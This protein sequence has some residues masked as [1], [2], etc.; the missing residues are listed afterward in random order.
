MTLSVSFIFHPYNYFLS[1]Y[2]YIYY[3]QKKYISNKKHVTL[4]ILPM[5]EVDGSFSEH[6]FNEIQLYQR[7]QNTIMNSDNMHIIL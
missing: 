2:I 6:R 4:Q 3:L 1:N 5:K 7:K